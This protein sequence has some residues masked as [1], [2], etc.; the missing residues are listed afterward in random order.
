MH[1]S[2]VICTKTR[3]CAALHFIWNWIISTLPFI[4]LEENDVFSPWGPVFPTGS[5][6][7]GFAFSHFQ[8]LDPGPVFR[9]CHWNWRRWGRA[10]LLILWNF[11]WILLDDLYSCFWQELIFAVNKISGQQFSF[12]NYLGRYIAS[13]CNILNCFVQCNC[14]THTIK[15]KNNPF[16]ESQPQPFVV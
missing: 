14:F 3:P 13:F 16:Q 11:F 7:R 9:R 4:W 1:F 8:G 10:L 5:F 2:N 12:R 6:F 15:L